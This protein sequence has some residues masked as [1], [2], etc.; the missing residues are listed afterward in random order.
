MTRESVAAKAARYLQEGRLIVTSVNGD[1]VTAWCRG[2]GEVYELGH[3]L[4]RG[5]YCGCVARTDCSHL[6][7]LRLVTT[8]RPVACAPA[9]RRTA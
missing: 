4:A 1:R 2:D 7:A 5:W 6:T 3:D 8:R 9:A